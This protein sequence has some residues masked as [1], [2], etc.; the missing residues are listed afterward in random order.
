MNKHI[1]VIIPVYNGSLTIGECLKALFSSRYDNFEVIVVDDSSEDDSVKLIKKFPCKIIELNK[2]FGAS[3]A[4]NIGAHNSSGEILFFIDADCIVQEDTLYLVNK[5]F[6]ENEDAIIGGTYSRIPFD[7]NFFSTFQSIF[8]NYSETKKEIPD[9]IPGHAMVINRSVF[10]KSNGF[11]ENFLPILEDVE[12]SHRLRRSGFNLK[13][14]PQITLKHIFNFTLISSLRNA[15]RKSMYWSMYSLKNRDLLADSGTAGLELKRNV[16][17][18][19]LNTLLIILF[20]YFKE[21]GFLFP[22]SLVFA[23]N[24]FLSRRLLREFYRVKGF[25][26]FV[27]AMLYYTLFYPLGVGAGALS[28]IIRYIWIYKRV[29]V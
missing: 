8:I 28:G 21:I 11:A 5:A 25:S 27:F 12:F 14:N 16:L 17:A 6:L 15:F 10:M 26:F 4:R 18:F 23:T 7:D 13:M 20:F 29:N 3:K 9:Y 22:V 24:L 1:S 2:H 19:F